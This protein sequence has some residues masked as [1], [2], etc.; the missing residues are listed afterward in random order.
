MVFLG[1]ESPSAKF[2][3]LLVYKQ[4]TLT[5]KLCFVLGQGQKSQQKHTTDNFVGFHNHLEGHYRF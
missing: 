3:L 4:G 2:L 5:T 1:G